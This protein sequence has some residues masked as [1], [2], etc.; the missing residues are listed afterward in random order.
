MGASTN[1]GRASAGVRTLLQQL[2]ARPLEL[3]SLPATDLDLVLR[4]ARRVRL[5]GWLAAQLERA[6]RLKSLPEAAAEQLESALATAEA[7]ARMARWELDRIAWALRDDGPDKVIALKGC[8]YLLRNL[9][10]A[11]G[12][13]FADVDLLVAEHDLAVVETLLK[14]RGWRGTKLSEYD[15]RFYREWA[16]ELP[17]LVHEE[18]EVEVD[19]HHNIRGR[20]APFKPDAA[21]LLESAQQVGDSGFCSLADVD[22]VLHA[23]THMMYGGDL[24]DGLRDLVDIDMLLRHFAARDDEFWGRVAP[25]ATELN[26]RL[27]AFYTLRYVR[28]LFGTAI[29]AGVEAA[30]SS[31]APSAPVLAMMDRLVPLA[32]FPQHPDA[33][34]STAG[35]ARWLLYIRSHWVSMPPVM[36]MR[37]LTYKFYVRQ[38][39]GRL[40]RADSRT[41]REA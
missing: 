23:M 8:T 25:R 26:L 15:Q 38:V 40:R 2:V 31:A 14:D 30:L 7:R 21:R 28:R 27:P 16:H 32:L 5:L 3:A 24:A 29:P 41:Q 17:A 9:P 12:R 11:R 10:N 6:E 34:G 33:P 39:S 37:H 18:R 20:F 35:L 4:A 19:V 22:L 13:L 36:L 1:A